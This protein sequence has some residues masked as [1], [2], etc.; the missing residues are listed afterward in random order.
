[1][2]FAE[3]PARSPLVSG[4]K[5]PVPELI[6]SGSADLPTELEK[7]L[8]GKIAGLAPDARR[9]IY[10]E[11]RA[12]LQSEVR[13][14][15]PFMPVQT[16]VA[17]RRELENAIMAVE[18][19]AARTDP[20]RPPVPVRPKPVPTELAIPANS[21]TTALAFEPERE[22]EI[23]AA[24]ETG[25]SEPHEIDHQSAEAP[26]I[27]ETTTEFVA[28]LG[29]DAAT[30]ISPERSPTETV[31][32][33][34]RLADA[35]EALTAA[36]HVD[37]HVEE[38][39]E[40]L[41]P[42]KVLRPL[43]LYSGV[44]ALAVC[45]VALAALIVSFGLDQ[46]QERAVPVAAAPAPVVPPRPVPELIR[47]AG[48]Q[49]ASQDA[50]KEGNAHLA[51]REFDRAISFF[52]DAIRL[53]P[54]A[55][56]Y[57]NRAF[58]HWNKGNTEAAIRDYGAAIERDPS[59]VANR[60]NRAVAYNRAGEYQRAVDDLD[61]ALALEPANANALNSRCW[62]R[63]VLAHLQEALADCNAALARRPTDADTLDS[64]GF[65]YLRLG[66]LD[67]AIADYSGVLKVQPKH[68]GSLY[69]RGLARIGR[70]DRAGGNEDIAAARAIDP[71]I[72]ATFAR[73]GV[74]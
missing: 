8:A 57:G 32:E 46:A 54:S 39:I 14:A 24:Q 73:Y 48:F 19:E 16:V 63:A 53:E 30:E 70:G 37:E 45:A 60:I 41:P 51:R 7:H 28:G 1:M 17:R 35:H 23:V 66:R 42:A 31:V 22:P 64:R 25:S 29:V 13:V 62:A 9:A 11:V 59:N 18:R 69:G 3:G 15:A 40:K 5:R 49:T 65:V 68:A 44:L 47:G 4:Y 36:E 74:R 20:P 56:A 27:E 52:D 33:E 61:R 71:E 43:L 21:E 38:N 12:G 72:V 58:A 10:D 2:E 34:Q 55:A 67:R 6:S 50:L 26:T